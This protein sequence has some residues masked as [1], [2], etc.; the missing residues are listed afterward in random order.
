MSG[1]DVAELRRLSE[2]VPADEWG[3][4]KVGYIFDPGGNAVCNVNVREEGD[5][6]DTGRLIAYLGTYRER[7]LAMLEAA[8]A[9]ALAVGDDHREPDFTPECPQCTALRAYDQAAKG[10]A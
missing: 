5:V 2:A 3:Y 8:D 1:F 6:A 7:I 10:G 9:L 4:T